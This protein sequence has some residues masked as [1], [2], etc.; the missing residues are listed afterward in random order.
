MNLKI[1]DEE[2]GYG[3]RE[4]VDRDTGKQTSL[5]H[6]SGIDATWEVERTKNHI[7]CRNSY[8]CM[9]EYG[10]YDGW[11][12]FSLKIPKKNPEDFDLH[13]HTDSAGWYRVGKYMLRQYLE[14]L[15]AG[16]FEELN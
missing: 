3:T 14:D 6:G 13:F 7:I 2:N 11:I 15:F 16:T 8:H 9:D 12:D 4:I 5:P 1:R 10:Y